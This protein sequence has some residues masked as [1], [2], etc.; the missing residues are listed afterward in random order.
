MKLIAVVSQDWG[1]GDRG[2]LLFSL[3]GDLK[4]FKALTMGET[5]L[6]GRATLDSLPGG[7]ALPGR[8]NLVLTRDRA[9]CRENVIVLHSIAEALRLP[10][11]IWVMGG[12]SVYQA[13]LPYCETAEI[14]YVRA[15][16]PADRFLSNLDA[17]P[18]WELVWESAVQEEGGILYTFRRYRNRETIKTESLD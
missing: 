18:Q 7:R 12:A 5:V 14:T 10:G 4:H 11:P 15:S 17:L 13:L 6:M 2:G 9:F 16:R 3:P 8:T 1:L